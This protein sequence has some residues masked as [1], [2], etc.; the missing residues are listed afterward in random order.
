MVSVQ[1]SDRS[2]LTALADR[3]GAARA[4]ALY[5]SAATRSTLQ[6]G[7]LVLGLDVSVDEASA[8][9]IEAARVGAAGVVLRPPGGADDA[10]SIQWQADTLGVDLGWLPPELTWNDLHRL[11]VQ[12]LAPPALAPD[13]ELGDLAQTIATLTGGLVTIEDTSARVLAYSRSSD[14]VDELRRLSILGRSGPP[15]YLALLREWGVYDRLAASEEVVEI[16]EH[17][18]SGV[19]R[20]LAVGIFAGTRQLGTIWVQQGA[21]KFGPH[22]AQALLGAARITA[23][24][25]A[26][27]HFRPGNRPA[28]NGLAALLGGGAPPSQLGRAA[29]KPCVVAVFEVAG[30][31]EGPA[32]DRLR[33]D[34]LTAIVTVHAAAYRRNALVEQLDGR[35]YVLLPA[36]ETA[37]S[38]IT[39]LSQAVAAARLHLDATAR[40]AVGGV[41]DSIAQAARSRR[42]ADLTLATGGQRPG[43]A[44]T[45]GGQR[46][47]GASE[48]ILSFEAARPRLVAELLEQALSARPELHDHRFGDLVLADPD[49]ARTLLA[50][51]DTGSDVARVA[52]E[53]HVHPTTVR[54]R[55]R[56]VS[57]TLGLDLDDADNRLSAQLHLRC[58]LRAA[59]STA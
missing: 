55:L 43:G 20:R 47:G 15:E 38:A 3:F 10:A 46:P 11:L 16:A 57:D 31:D 23:T 42:E 14:E 13:D 35:V 59:T 2:I 30:T 32:A 44:L 37:T 19:R 34:E 7:D 1:S 29:R 27:Q 6:V 58:G 52:A 54:Y 18:E 41:A 48:S 40:A 50:Y 8:L 12:R 17:P 24:Q 39:M 25:L 22:A 28:G 26:A 21:V 5:E 51:L 33:L 36:V 53:L 9:L 49:G 4:V 56:K 45:G